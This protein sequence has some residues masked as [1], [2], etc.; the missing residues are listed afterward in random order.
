MKSA[1]SPAHPS[2]HL[3]NDIISLIDNPNFWFN[4]ERTPQGKVRRAG[5][6]LKVGLFRFGNDSEGLSLWQLLKGRT[7]LSEDHLRIK[8]SSSSAPDPRTTFQ[9]YLSTAWRKGLEME[10][11]LGNE[12]TKQITYTSLLLMTEVAE[13]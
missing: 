1:S 9:K 3:L 13:L 6:S 4:Q 11:L 5:S 10:E 8:S 12:S 2:E 7:L